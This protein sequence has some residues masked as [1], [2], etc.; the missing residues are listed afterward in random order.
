MGEVREPNTLSQNEPPVTDST[1]PGEIGT[2]PTDFGIMGTEYE[3]TRTFSEEFANNLLGCGF[4]VV[5][6]GF[7]LMLIGILI[8]ELWGEAERDPVFK[9][10][11]G[12]VIIV[13]CLI[14][15]GVIVYTMISRRMRR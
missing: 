1:D 11:M 14:V 5:F 4:A 2:I 10:A 7:I 3:D 13:V 12:V 9:Q 15:I 6:G 8:M